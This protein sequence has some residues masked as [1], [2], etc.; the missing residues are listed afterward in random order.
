MIKGKV[1]GRERVVK[2]L[3]GVTPAVHTALEKKIQQLVI[4]LQRLVVQDKLQGEVLNVRTGRLQRSINQVMVSQENKVSGI[5]STNVVYAHAQE[6]GF[7]GTVNVKEHLR[8]LTQAFGK[9]L[10]SPVQVTVKA[11]P[12]KMNLDPHS[13]LRSAL[14]EMADDVINGIEDAVKEGLQK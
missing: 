9:E 2:H 12:M 13:F 10:K 3:K 11:H 4:R 6:Y 1:I 5:V 8:T 7:K 14:G